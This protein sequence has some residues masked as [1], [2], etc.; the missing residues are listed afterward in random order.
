MSFTDPHTSVPHHD[1]APP[2][3]GAVVPQGAPAWA[4]SILGFAF[5]GVFLAY[6]GQTA[7]GVT[8]HT[9]GAW[10]IVGLGLLGVFGLC[11]L[12]ALARWNGPTRNGRPRAVLVM[13]GAM[14]AC[15]IA[16]APLAHEDVWVMY[17]F[18]S[19]LLVGLLG[20]WGLVAVTGLT[21]LAMFLP[22]AV[23]SWD[24][25]VQWSPAFT[26][27]LISLALFAFFAVI[28]ANAELTDARGEIARLA[29]EGERSRIA[30]DLHD[31][32]GHSLTSITIKSGLA[33]R[34]GETDP[35]GAAREIAEVEALAR[36]ALSDVRAAVG[37]YRE[38]TLTSELA[39]ASEV[40]RAA[41]ITADLPGAVDIVDVAYRELFGWVVREGLTNV[42]RHARA[43][44]CAVTLGAAQVV[45][46][47]DGPGGS[48]SGASG[49]SHR[50]D[51]NR[52]GS[53]LAG[54]RERVA[55]AGGTLQVGPFDDPTG[56]GRGWRLAVTM[57][58][59]KRS[60]E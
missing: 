53:G 26:I 1:L 59:A 3:R 24:A 32:L 17:V 6:L 18:I 50:V 52:H 25:G 34:L 9:N 21:L 57:P 37:G 44:R 29:A 16:V 58:D 13:L 43:T 36:E 12:V 33:R 46:T 23:P 15:T 47:D 4:K 35:V 39:T 31:L 48:G 54:L 7:Y 11:Y 41:G 51:S 55:A 22:L 38:V 60:A 56:A 42:V 5:P 10:T 49:S 2:R 27:P 28:H 45:I 30:R 19:A 20:G 14:V 8:R 40:L